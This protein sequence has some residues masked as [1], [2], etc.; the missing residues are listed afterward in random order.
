M[1]AQ[2]RHGIVAGSSGSDAVLKALLWCGAVSGLVYLAADAIASTVLQGYVFQNQAVSE[3]LAIEASTRPLMLALMSVYNLLI[4]AFAVGVWAAAGVRR[5]LRITSVMLVIYAVVG[6]LTQL[7]SPMHVR[8]SGAITA[9]DMGHILLTA[10]EVLSIVLFISLGSGARGRG[11]RVYSIVSILLIMA[12]GIITGALSTHMTALASS[13]PLAGLAE[14]VNI[15]GTMIWIAALGF[16]LMRPALAGG[17]SASGTEGAGSPKKVTAFVGSGHRAGATYTAARMFLDKLAAFGDVDTDLVVL[18]DY[19]I[20]LCRGCKVCFERGEEFCPLK[21]DRDVLIDKLMT[22]DAVVIATPNYSFQVS[23]AT[24]VFLDRLG[25]AFHRPRFHGKTFTSIV[26]Q[27]IY[28]GRK[29]GSYLDF[30]GGGLGFNTVKGS[31]LRTLEPMTDKASADMDATLT[32]QAVRFHDRMLHDALPTPSLFG[33][34][35][36]RMG[37]TSIRL[38]LTEAVADYRYYR[39]HG[40]FESD[41]YY[42]TH[43]GP[44]KR[45]IGAV[46]D[47]IAGRAYASRAVA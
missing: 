25:F 8:G 17:A 28:G 1:G 34:F 22:S 21:D 4:L 36:F 33:L 15:Y 38:M 32:K 9:T 47:L 23:G 19:S 26:V 45:A 31:V 37:R 11:F 13:T 16:A 40:W 2:A 46:V 18:S 39:D 42:P 35:A 44:V 29:I 3:L 43:L 5:S 10:V 24:K 20:G 14:R 12:G 27:G 7:F 30:V 6:E 41:Y